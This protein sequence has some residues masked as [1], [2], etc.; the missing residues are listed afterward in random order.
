MAALIPVALAGYGFSDETTWRAGAVIFL[1][2]NYFSIVSFITSYSPV[3][4]TFTP[5]RL[6]FMIAVML[7]VFIHISLITIVLGLAGD[8]YYGLYIS[9][10][11]ATIGQAAF[12]FLRLVESTFSGIVIQPGNPT[13]VES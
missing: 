3:K 2:L 7:Q 13:M 4:E 5:D 9:A 1:V 8:R 6:A 10:L 12:V 11:I